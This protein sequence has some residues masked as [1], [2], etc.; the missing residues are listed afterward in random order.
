MKIRNKNKDNYY[1]KLNLFILLLLGNNIFNYIL[2]ILIYY[3][4]N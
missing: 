4:N 1:F 3:L 2:I